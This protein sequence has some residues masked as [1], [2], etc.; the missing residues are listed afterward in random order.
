MTPRK[1]YSFYIEDE[2]AEALKA[3]K[4][5]DGVLES[6]QIRRALDDWIEKKGVSAKATSRRAR[7]RRKV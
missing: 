4:E 7:T 2:Q 1:K 6:E 3:I 5:R